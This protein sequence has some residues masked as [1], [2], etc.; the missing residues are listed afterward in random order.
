[1]A[2]TS[3]E[4]QMAEDYVASISAGSTA[5]EHFDF[6]WMCLESE[7]M[8]KVCADTT[9]NAIEGNGANSYR[10]ERSAY[11][12][13]KTTLYSKTFKDL[14]YDTSTYSGDSESV[15]I[16]F[17]SPYVESSGDLSLHLNVLDSGEIKVKIN[18]ATILPEDW[19]STGEYWEKINIPTG[20]IDHGINTLTISFPNDG[21]EIVLLEDS[22]INI[23]GTYT[24]FKHSPENP[25]INETIT[26]N[27]LSSYENIMGYGW[28]F[29]DGTNAIGET[30]THAYSMNREYNVTLV[31]THN[32]DETDMIGKM[33]FA[34][35]SRRQYD[36]TVEETGE[37]TKTGI[38]TMTFRGREP[39]DEYDASV[40]HI[41]NTVLEEPSNYKIILANTGNFI[42]KYVTRDEGSF[43]A[44][45]LPINPQE[46]MSWDDGASLLTNISIPSDPGTGHAIPHYI[47]GMEDIEVPAGNFR[48]F[49][50]KAEYEGSRGTMN[51]WSYTDEWWDGEGG[52]LIQA[53][54]TDGASNIATWPIIFRGETIWEYK[55]KENK[56]PHKPCNPTPYNDA[57][58]VDTNVDLSWGGGDPD[59][60]P[61]TYDVY[62]EKGDNSPDE[63]ISDDQDGTTY[64][65]GTLDCGSHYYWKIVAKDEHGSTNKSNVWHFCTESEADTTSPAS[66]TNL[67]ATNPD[68]NSIKLTWTAPGDDNNTGI[69]TAYD[70]RYLEGASVTESNWNFGVRCTGK[71]SPG[72]AGSAE[73]YIVT[74]LSP[75]TTYYFALKTVDEVPNWSPISNSPDETTTEAPGLPVHNLNTD[76]NFATIR[77]AIDD[78]N[79]ADG[80][81]ITVDAGIYVENVDVNKQL[82]IISTSMNHLDTVVRAKNYS[83][84]VFEVTVD[85]VKIAGF[86]VEGATGSF[87]AGMYLG[88]GVDHCDVSDNNVSKNEYG[89]YLYFSNNNIL[90]NNIANSNS[91][92]IRLYKSSNNTLKNNTANQNDYYGIYLKSSNNSILTNNT[93]NSNN[94]DGIRLRSHSNNNTL[95]NNIANSNGEAGLLCWASFDNTLTHNNIRLNARGIWIYNSSIYNILAKNT[96]NSNNYGIQLSRSNKNTVINNNANSNNKYGIRLYSS[97]DN[98]IYLNNFI[99]NSNGDYSYNSTNFF[100]SSSE[101]KYVYNGNT[102]INYTGNHWDDYDGPDD[103]KDGI[104]DTPH[105]I[106]LDKDNYPLIKPFENYSADQERRGD[107]NND[108]QITPAD[109]AIALQIAASGAHNDAADVSGDGCVTS[110]DALMILQAA[111][112]NI[113]I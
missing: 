62:F 11:L 19:F 101:M 77:T 112:G 113:G 69:A 38:L 93:A 88:T 13:L 59:G 16:D 32:G 46:G 37:E 61:V 68:S 66:V 10:E 75:G 90:T 18:G 56:P 87:K 50:V 45:L 70:I 6:V 89:I 24:I 2:L 30:V 80:H 98:M 25:I 76:E 36:A 83:D 12:Q 5:T 26:F 29:G 43:Y 41:A 20:M 14:G 15:S 107:L 31:V 106:R 49:H 27:A 54:Y 23:T 17:S 1:M 95:S 21:Y 105:S 48:C 91:C 8:V 57:T 85:D 109:A 84:H 53:N 97:S 65:P 7:E 74:G 55:L 71:P 82:T 64:N 9:N 52:G 100:N 58:D 103:N 99:N 4:C 94:L 86:T 92:G 39:V 40:F 104:G 102:Y 44:K 60:D 35:I 3:G 67:V 96:A 73:I 111:A 33:I 72:P 110:L 34:G 28:D 47:T 108:N 63:L 22:V 78:P 79:T 42:E 81:T 51:W